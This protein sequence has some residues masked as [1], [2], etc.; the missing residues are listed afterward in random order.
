MNWYH[1]FFGVSDSS[2]NVT[3]L[4]DSESDYEIETG[5]RRGLYP[6]SWLNCNG[7]PPFEY[8]GKGAP[9][10]FLCPPIT[11][12]LLLS[13]KAKAAFEEALVKGILYRPADVRTKGGEVL[14]YWYVVTP[15]EFNSLCFRHCEPAFGKW[16]EYSLPVVTGLDPEISD[17]WVGPH[18]KHLQ[19]E[20]FSHR[21]VTAVRSFR[22]RSCRI[23]NFDAYTTTGEDGLFDLCDDQ[24]TFR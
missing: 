7:D 9:P 18:T 11:M 21:F 24:N 22:L 19:L 6:V 15:F 3:K 8:F 14:T 4:F 10:D 1:C 16:Y 23:V 13:Q 17:V 2:F 12:G 5:Q 20:V